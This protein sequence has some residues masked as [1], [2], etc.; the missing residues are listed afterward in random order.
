MTYNEPYSTPIIN[1]KIGGTN[2]ATLLRELDYNTE[3]IPILNPQVTAHSTSFSKEYEGKEKKSFLQSCS[4]IFCQLFCDHFHPKTHLLI[5]LA[6]F[7][8]ETEARD[9][10]IPA[11]SLTTN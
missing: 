8:Q 10:K 11:E 5:H 2:P 9:V 3:L 7:R 6:F 1:P 4:Q